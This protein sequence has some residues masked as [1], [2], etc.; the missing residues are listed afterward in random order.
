MELD[1]QALGDRIGQAGAAAVV[2]LSRQERLAVAVRLARLRQFDA[3]YKAGVADVVDYVTMC[4][5]DRVPSAETAE[6]VHTLTDGLMILRDGCADVAPR[7]K[8][9]VTP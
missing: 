7:N 4:L 5:R 6:L 3:E 1:P 2:F 9:E 8:K